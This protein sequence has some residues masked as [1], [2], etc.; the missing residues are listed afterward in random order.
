MSFV[1]LQSFSAGN[2]RNLHIISGFILIASHVGLFIAFYCAGI[3]FFVKINTISIITYIIAICFVF[4]RRF[5]PAIIISHIEIVWYASV[6]V[7][8][9]GWGYGFEYYIFG[10]FSLLYFDTRSITR[11]TYLISLCEFFIFLGL[12]F[13]T[14][15]GMPI[16]FSS[17]IP[18][19]VLEYQN[20]ILIANLFVVCI[21]L[22]LYQHL[23]NIDSAI[24][25]IELSSQRELYE[26]LANYDSLTA[27]L[28][29]QSFSE[30]IKKRYEKDYP[31]KTAVLMVDIDN[32]KYIN[33]RYGHNE[34][35]AVLIQVAQILKDVGE[36]ENA[37][38]VSRWGGEE[39]VI[40]VY[41]INS[42]EQL[43]R[44]A[45]NV[46]SA[47]LS[48]QFEGLSESVSVS[49]GGC[50]SKDT[51]LSFSDYEAMLQ[52]ADEN[53]YACKNMGRGIAKSTQYI[54]AK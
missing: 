12:Y 43:Q 6:S 13:Y 23:F 17:H 1:A 26:R 34:G 9:F 46:L 15:S 33:D 37:N 31:L 24:R 41:D 52:Q 10:L 47:V 27:I 53:L 18:P 4:A 54:K 50:W 16:I 35:D 14:K 39:F 32:F 40:D 48:H 42:V 29:R 30:I 22:T 36:H 5:T 51:K 44:Y 38:L 3:D 21:F 8:A 11:I 7:L 49:I 20:I 19:A 45:Q 25:I 2:E 28:N